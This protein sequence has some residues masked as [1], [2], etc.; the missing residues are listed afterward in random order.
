MIVVLMWWVLMVRWFG[1]VGVEVV[2][3]LLMLPVVGR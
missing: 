2:V 1:V 3:V